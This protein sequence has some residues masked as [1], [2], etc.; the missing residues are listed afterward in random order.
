VAGHPLMAIWGLTKDIMGAGLH[1][2]INTLISKKI[3]V[4]GWKYPPQDW[5]K[6]NVDGYSKCNPGLTATGGLIRDC[7]GSWIRGFAINTGVCTSVRV[8]L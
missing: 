4:V 5:M 7:M 2:K 6:L 8:E 1:E 3:N